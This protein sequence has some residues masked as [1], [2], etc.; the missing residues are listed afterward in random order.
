MHFPPPNLRAPRCTS[1]NPFSFE[2][3]FQGV[4]LPA[5]SADE[6]SNSSNGA[7]LPIDA[8]LVK[9]ASSLPSSTPS[10]AMKVEGGDDSVGEKPHVVL[11]NA[12]ATLGVVLSG[13]EV[14]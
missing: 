2:Q 5:L 8:A 7:R 10:D 6:G 1:P 11:R 4:L 14:R 12:L 3:V 13:Y 9:G